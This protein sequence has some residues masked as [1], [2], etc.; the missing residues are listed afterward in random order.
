MSR[1]GGGGKWTFNL[2]YF[3]QSARAQSDDLRN[4]VSAVVPV[5]AFTQYSP[6]RGII[7]P[8]R[9]SGASMVDRSRYIASLLLVA[10]LCG[11]AA[12]SSAAPPAAPSS[13]DDANLPC[14]EVQIGKDRAGLL[15][16]LNQ[17]FR[18]S[19][20]GQRTLQPAA[21]YGTSS[22]P[23]QIGLFNE[24]AERERLGNAFGH[25]AVPQRP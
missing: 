4:A 7:M 16:C 1:F 8:S 13:P 20:D 19:A 11:G 21:P 15:D 18:R 5:R 25:S 23:N 10:L 12:V 2:G 17:Q 14:V 24:T 9:L 6:I 22:P 3:M